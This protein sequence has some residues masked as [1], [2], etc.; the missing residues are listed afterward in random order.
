MRGR[1][2]VDE[3]TI[4]GA[5]DHMPRLHD[6]ATDR[7][8]APLARGFRLGQRKVH[9]IRLGHARLRG[10]GMLGAGAELARKPMARK[11]ESSPQEAERIAKVMAR[12]G[13]CS[14][15]EAESWIAAGRVAV[16][17]ET[18]TSPARNV[19]RRDEVTVDGKPLPTRERT[20]LFRYHK[21]S[22]LL[23][24]S[25]D[26]Q[27]RPTL[28][29]TL[30]AR[31]P[32]LV[33]IGRL[34]FNSEGLLLLTNDGGL[35]RAL[36]LPETGWLRR[37]RVRA[38]GKATQEDLDRLRH[39][40]TVD[41]ISYGPVDAKLDRQQGANVWLTIGL[42]EGK[43]REVRNVLR[44]IG[45]HVNRLIRVSYGPFQLAELAPGAVE[46]VKMRTLQEQLSERLAR[47]AGVDFT[48]PL[49]EPAPAEAPIPK[50][51]RADA[52]VPK[53]RVS[54]PPLRRPQRKGVGRAPRSRRRR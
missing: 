38:N 17:G 6:D 52:P 41:G 11:P 29:A 33:S 1:I 49:R 54:A 23:T 45:L 18:L 32:R 4:A 9:E 31:L 21:P 3:C 12:A 7:H 27:G 34:D 10:R 36:E 48:A 30:P 40:V 46:E 47:E 44:S 2:L 13:L 51:V 16:N 8:L 35:K 43:N 25:R 50:P 37:Y 53:A 20:R 24:T 19:S 26:P 14:R 42:R 28:F 22:G 5:G 15:R 39:G